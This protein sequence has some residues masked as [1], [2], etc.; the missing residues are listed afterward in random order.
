MNIKKMCRNS[1]F[2]ITVLISTFFVSCT[3]SERVQQDEKA[4]LEQAQR[5]EQVRFEIAAI[6][7]QVSQIDQEIQTATLQKFAGDNDPTINYI[8]ETKINKLR[9]ERE[10]R[11]ARLAILQ[12]S[13]YK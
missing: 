2:I 7:S 4:R 1:I 3:D 13:L 6:V 10:M 12:Q 11:T 8:M 5:D 9:S